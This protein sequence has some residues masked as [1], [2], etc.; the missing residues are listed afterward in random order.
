MP[1]VVKQK[2]YLFFAAVLLLNVSF[3]QDTAQLRKAEA[4]KVVVTD[5]AEKIVAKLGIT[6]AAKYKTVREEIAQHYIDLNNIYDE[7]DAKLKA[8]KANTAL[9][10]AA[11]DAS[12]KTIEA[13]VDTKLA[14][15]HPKFLNQLSKNLSVAQIDM[16]KDGLTYNVVNVTY[17]GYQDMIPMLTEP[18]KAQILAWLIEAREHA[19]DAESSDKKHAWF[20]KYK[21]RINNYL[22]AQGYDSQKERENWEKRIKAAAEA[23]KQPS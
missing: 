2:F 19:I 6:D 4:Y 15:L 18:Q 9:D 8:L 23:K 1:L 3:A 21:G 20:G 5:R 12:K 13:D 17:K 11:I 22:S 10:K 7:R 16:V 14:D